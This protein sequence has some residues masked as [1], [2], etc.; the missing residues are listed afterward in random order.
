M[1]AYSATKREFVDDVNNN[2]IHLRIQDLLGHRVGQ[3]EVR[4][5][6][7]SLR[8]MESVIRDDEI[9]DDAGVS[10]EF[11]IPLTSK[12]VDFIL[13]G[14]DAEQN[15][16]AVIVELKQWDEVKPTEKDGVVRAFVGGGERELTHPSYQAWTYA[17]LIHDFN[18]TVREDSIALAPCAYLHNLDSGNVVNDPFLCGPYR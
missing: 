11:R 12:R 3:S 5:W 8:A 13:T 9:P 6:R 4:S 7:N 15:E 10:I 1:L 16:S 18:E 17:A 14:K 2:V